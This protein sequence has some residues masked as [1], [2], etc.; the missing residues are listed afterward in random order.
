MSGCRSVNVCESIRRCGGGD[1][2]E[3]R[4]WKE[5]K[6]SRR[7]ASLNQYEGEKSRWQ[8]FNGSKYARELCLAYVSRLSFHF[9]LCVSIR[10]GSVGRVRELY[11]RWLSGRIG[12]RAAV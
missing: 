5:R 12:M 8:V 6:R 9:C 2:E 11:C 1:G 10:L 3:S 4:E 7:D